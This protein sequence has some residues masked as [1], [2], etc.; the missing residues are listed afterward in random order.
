LTLAPLYRKIYY[1][2]ITNH[3]KWKVFLFLAV[4]S[5][6]TF[7]STLVV[8]GDFY[9]GIELRP[10][11]YAD[12]VISPIYF[13]DE[14]EGELSKVLWMPSQK[15][16]TQILEAFV[17]HMPAF[18]DD[19]KSLCDYNKSLNNDSLNK[20]EI[21]LNCLNQFYDLRLNDQ[22]ITSQ[23]FYTKSIKTGQD[24]LK[25]FIPIDSLERGRHTIKLY[26]NFYNKGKDTIYKNLWAKT[27]FYKSTP[28]QED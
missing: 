1:T 8:K 9:N 13:L 12:N 21:K 3:R 4:F 24:G 22:T 11:D 5:L 7:I 25:Y 2:F 17:V 28:K 27:E 23:F 26:Y 18:E 6:I 15:I 16:G 20:D 19:I 10:N 14:A